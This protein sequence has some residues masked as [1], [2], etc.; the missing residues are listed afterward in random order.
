MDLLSKLFPGLDSTIGGMIPEWGEFQQPWEILS[1]K[2]GGLQSQIVEFASESSGIFIHPTA[3]IGEGVVIEGPCYIGENA[4]VR[5]SAYI[6]KGSWI[7][8]GAIVGHS[9][10]VKNSIML[11]NAK[12]PHFN[13]VGDSILGFDVNLGAGTKLSNVRNDRMEVGV[14]LEGGVRVDSKMKK[15]GALVGDGSHL[16]CNVVTNPGA[17]MMPGTMVRPNE[18]ITGWKG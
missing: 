16:G 17:I 6:R 13:Y 12:A 1:E 7:C 8:F 4:E 15:L 5:H 11:P 18:T 3:K 10:E 14:F 9:S 2:K